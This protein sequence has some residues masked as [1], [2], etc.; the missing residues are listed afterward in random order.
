MFF[1]KRGVAPSGFEPARSCTSS[2][3]LV[4]GKHL[5]ESNFSVTPVDTEIAVEA[6]YVSNF[7]AFGNDDER[8]I[9]KISRSISVFE[10]QFLDSSVFL[11][12]ER[13]NPVEPHRDVVEKFV[14]YSMIRLELPHHLSYNRFCCYELPSETGEVRR[15]LLMPVI[16]GAVVSDDRSCIDQ[17]GPHLL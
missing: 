15:S 6:G 1:C 2:L 11:R 12:K 7:Q 17:N 5:V 8:K 4:L 14:L 13:F 16:I 9:G 10:I 3:V